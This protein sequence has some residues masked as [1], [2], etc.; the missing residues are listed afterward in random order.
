MV[1]LAEKLT[2]CLIVSGD[3]GFSYDPFTRK[4]NACDL[5]RRQEVLLR[6]R[7]MPATCA[8]GICL[9]RRELET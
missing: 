7:K 6:K 1:H 8:A 2:F 4:A 9:F 3:E 5:G